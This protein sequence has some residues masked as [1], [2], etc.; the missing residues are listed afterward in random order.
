MDSLL[1]DVP[2]AVVGW[3]GSLSVLTFIG[4]LVAVP[5]IVARIPANYFRDERRREA[6]LHRMH[7]LLYV[8]VRV[9]KN[10][11]AVVLVIG[12]ILMLV[13]PGQGILTILIGIGVSDFP[14]KY[15]LE[16]RLVCLPGVLSAINWIRRK[17]S[18][19]A[20][21]PPA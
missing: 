13:L 8:L 1:P 16:R 20:L 2:A 9:L 12:G 11:L 4:S 18:V 7:P 5:I 14:G 10:A 15:H 6:S 21:Q 17:S 19:D 3:I